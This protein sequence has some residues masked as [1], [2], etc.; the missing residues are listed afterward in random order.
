MR[1]TIAWCVMSW[2]L[3]L[4]GTAAGDVGRDAGASQPGA[5]ARVE[6]SRTAVLEIGSP[7]PAL[8]I[9]TWVRGEAVEKFEPGKV[10]VVEF[11]ATW[12]QPCRRAVP[13][14]SALQTRHADAGLR[15]IGVSSQEHAGVADLER[16]AARMAERVTYTLAWDDQGRSDRAWMSA[17]G[18]RG[19]PTAF[20]IDQ[21]GR[22]AWIGHPRGGLD[23]VV[24]RVLAG[25]W[26]LDAAAAEQRRRRDV[27]SRT[28]AMSRGYA[29]ATRAGDH[30]GALRIVEQ[31]IALDPEINAEWMV[32]K[33]Q[34]LAV[35][36]KE[37]QKAGAFGAELVDGPLKDNAEALVNLSLAILDD[38]GNEARDIALALRA[39]ERA[40][41]VTNGEDALVLSVLARAQLGAGQNGAAVKTQ[42][43]AVDLSPPGAER[44]EQRRR[45]EEIRKRAG[46]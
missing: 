3:L 32:A 15:V 22:I 42:E 7:A 14:L 19:I 36:L 27:Q 17:S 8:S 41:V 26:D 5:G 35:S 25:T 24:E 46:G 37:T 10:Y 18:S 4:V 2:G 6:P 9:K 28:A 21:Q 34:L 29:D 44:D 13:H 31:M 33:Y 38:P 39:A 12:C 16:F 30:L 23:R 1:R 45:L 40:S 20:V 11:W 43:R